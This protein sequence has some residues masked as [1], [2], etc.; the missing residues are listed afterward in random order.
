LWDVLHESPAQLT[1][2]RECRDATRASSSWIN[3]FRKFAAGQI[4]MTPNTVSLRTN[5]TPDQENHIIQTIT[6]VGTKMDLLISDDGSRGLVPEQKVS[7]VLL[8][9]EVVKQGKQISYWKGA[10]A[11]V[12]AL[13]LALG[14]AF[15]AH[16]LGGK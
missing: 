2:I 5:M 1:R 6:K 3:G 12:A 10:I 15:A 8:E 16:I 13:F 4:G 9:I 11:V 14:G 7:H